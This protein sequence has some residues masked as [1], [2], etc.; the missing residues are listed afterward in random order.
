[1]MNQLKTT[2]KLTPKLLERH[3]PAPANR[4]IEDVTIPNDLGLPLTKND[5]LSA[6]RIF[7]IGSS[8]GPDGIH[9]QH[10]NDL[11]S[12]ADIKPTL[13]TAI[14]A[15][16]NHLLQGHCPTEV[17]RFSFGSSLTALTKM[18]GGIC[19]IAVGY[20]WR[21]LAAKCA[22]TS[23]SAKLLNY[24]NPIQLGVG[25]RGGCEATR[26]LRHCQT[27]LHKRFQL[28]SSRCYVKCS[29]L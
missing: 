13:L 10:I 21:Q 16:V 12:C 9:P 15:L 19:P 5:V 18:T 20:Y 11:L 14:T 2:T 7:P 1:M 28:Y 6:V 29:V 8:S 4:I 22:N 23:A 27:R 3:P 25:V 26:R 24:F 17:E